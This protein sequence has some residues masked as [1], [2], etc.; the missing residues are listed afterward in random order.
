MEVPGLGFFELSGN[1]PLKTATNQLLWPLSRERQG[2]GVMEGRRL[3]YNLKAE[4]RQSSNISPRP[5]LP[6]TRPSLRMKT[7]LVMKLG[8]RWKE[9]GWAERSVEG[10]RTTQRPGQELHRTCPPECSVPKSLHEGHSPPIALPQHTS[11]FPYWPPCSS[12]DWHQ[13]H[14]C[15]HRYGPSLIPCTYPDEM[16]RAAIIKQLK[17]IFCA[18]HQRVGK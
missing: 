5:H 8:K 1:L 6:T 14:L 11:L 9:G 4:G 2:C 15:G 10:G 13:A 16:L 7:K 17:G 18:L 12:S 3:W